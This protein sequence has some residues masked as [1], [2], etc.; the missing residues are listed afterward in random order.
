MFACSSVLHVRSTT[1][2]NYFCLSTKFKFQI[3]TYFKKI[4]PM[5]KF[6]KVRFYHQSNKKV[7]FF[8][9]VWWFLQM[10]LNFFLKFVKP[11]R[12]CKLFER[13][14]RASHNNF[15]ERESTWE[16]TCRR[17]WW[18]VELWKRVTLL[19]QL[20][21]FSIFLGHLYFFFTLF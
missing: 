4:S 16:E 19:L 21:S 18:L 11:K 10:Y 20:S 5:L 2:F 12:S 3:L 8:S 13:K 7:G 1:A 9:F 14:S 15:G 17:F 6:Y